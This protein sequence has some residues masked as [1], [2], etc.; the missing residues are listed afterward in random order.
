MRHKQ[1]DILGTHCTILTPD[2]SID[3][4]YNTAREVS[5]RRR[6]YE[7]VAICVLSRCLREEGEKAV[8]V[9]RN[10]RE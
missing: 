6:G 10:C 8:F 9:Y 1:V 3:C 4:Q 7:G 5:E 2:P